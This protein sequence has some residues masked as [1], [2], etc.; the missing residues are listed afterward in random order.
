MSTNTTLQ[1]V[2]VFLG[3]GGTG[4]NELGVFPDASGLPGP[5]R[6]RIAADLGF[7]ETVF[8]ED[9]D[10]GRLHIHTP[11]VELPLAGH[12]LVGTAWLL[13]D[14]GRPLDVLAPPAGAVPTW[15]EGERVWIRADPDLA[16]AF[17]TRRL[18]SPAD[19]DALEG[20][21]AGVD[22]HVW[23]WQDEAAGDVRVRVFPQEMG[24]G[25]D[26]ATGAAALR[27]GQRLGRALTVHQ[28]T[29][30]RIDVRP[31]PGGTVEVGGRCALLETRR[32]PLP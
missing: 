25:E 13:A 30:S 20:G 27:L 26:E 8:V 4:G 14:S 19:V 17:D 21:E 31:G 23:A 22:L 1:I 29:G 18:A 16:P 24:I 9:A 12:P 7:S 6:Q 10:S 32:Y 15:S 2:T 3:E 11:A 28:G 5:S